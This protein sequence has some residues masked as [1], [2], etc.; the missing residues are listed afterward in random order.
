MSHAAIH[1]TVAA[2]IKRDAHYLLVEE[3]IG[4]QPVFNQPAGHLEPGES[5]QEAVIREVLEETARSFT[6]TGLVGVY[7]WQSPAGDTFVR[8]TFTGSVGEPLPGRSLDPEITAT[9]WLDRPALTARRDCM[10]S[11]LVL[12][13]IDDAMINPPL[14]LDCLH[15]VA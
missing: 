10:R 2:V 9:H 1:V 3:R 15:E 13:C 4:G 11:P 6:P 14:P 7:R 12:R 5:L 8:F